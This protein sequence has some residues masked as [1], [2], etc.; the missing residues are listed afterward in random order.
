MRTTAASGEIE[1]SIGPHPARPDWRVLR[2]TYAARP[3][4][5]ARIVAALDAIF[6]PPKTADLASHGQDAPDDAA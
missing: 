1:L 5:D 4:H 6:G 2:V 3:E